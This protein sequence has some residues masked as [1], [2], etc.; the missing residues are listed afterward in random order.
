MP[1]DVKCP[2]KPIKAGNPA[3]VATEE[4]QGHSPTDW[5]SRQIARSDGSDGLPRRAARL[6][7]RGTALGKRARDGHPGP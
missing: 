6:N 7:G 2:S 1:F 5:Q 4:S 3:Q